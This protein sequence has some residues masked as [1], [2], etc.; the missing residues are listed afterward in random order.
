[1][2]EATVLVVDDDPRILRFVRTELEAAGFH[3]LT[4]QDGVAALK[5]LEAESPDLIVL[6][7]LMPVMDGFE[8]LERLRRTS[9]LPVIILTA[10]ASDTDKVRGLDLGADDYLTKPFSAEELIARIR[11]MLR[12]IES[13]DGLRSQPFFSTRTGLTLDFARRKVMLYERQ[14]NL[15]RTEWQLLS[16]LAANAGKVMTP[17]EL[18]TKI[19]GHEYRNDIQYLRV[20]ISRLRHKIETDPSRPRCLRTVPGIGY[21]IDPS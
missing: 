11:S 9:T 15:S 4:A 14:V 20:W 8:T 10:R 19:W 7:I 13:T 21:V 6:D 18:L 17:E 5:V 12:R 1:M 16:Q 3:V 2:K